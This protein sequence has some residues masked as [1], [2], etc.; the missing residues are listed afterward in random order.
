MGMNIKKKAAPIQNIPNKY[1]LRFLCS[2]YFDMNINPI[3]IV[4]TT[5]MVLNIPWIISKGSG[6][7]NINGDIFIL[8]LAS[9]KLLF[10]FFIL[11]AL[12]GVI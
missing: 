7:P 6:G 11:Y 10:N 2:K 9:F 8:Q 3:Y 4:I 5:N 12:F 1:K